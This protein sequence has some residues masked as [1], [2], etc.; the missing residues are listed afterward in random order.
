MCQNINYK[1][2][3]NELNVKDMQKTC[4]NLTIYHHRPH[5]LI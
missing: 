5:G 1:I 3:D 4:L 2:T